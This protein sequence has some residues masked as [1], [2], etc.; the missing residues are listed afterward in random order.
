MCNFVSQNTQ[1]KNTQ[2][3]LVYK[4]RLLNT[5]PKDK[6]KELNGFLELNL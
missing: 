3:I 1:S 6:K 2:K 4:R 5:M